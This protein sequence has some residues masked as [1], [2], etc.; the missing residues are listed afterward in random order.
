MA[1][2]ST[3]FGGIKLSGDDAKAFKRQ[4]DEAKP[5]PLAERAYR[6]GRDLVEGYRTDG[7]VKIT[8]DR[9]Q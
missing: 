4:V 1:V 7:F 2:H 5:N 3:V 9:K 8:I 6:E